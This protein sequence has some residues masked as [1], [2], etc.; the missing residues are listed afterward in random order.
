MTAAV[1]LG[2]TLPREEAARALPDADLL[3]PAR[4][5]DLHRAVASGRYDTVLL[6]DGVFGTVPA[7]WHKEILDALHRGV[8]VVG[9][10]S[11]GAL[12]AVECEPF[13]M[14]G[15]GEV[16]AAYRSGATEDDDDVAV[17]HLGPE[18]AWA[19]LTVPMVTV[20]RALRRATE[21]GTLTPAEAADAESVAKAMFYAT[22]TWDRLTAALEAAGCMADAR[23]FVR[24]AARRENDAKA[25][26]CLAALR[27]VADPAPPAPDRSAGTG[28]TAAEDT[29][30]WSRLRREAAFPEVPGWLDEDADPHPVPAAERLR[31]VQGALLEPPSAPLGRDRRLYVHLVT[32]A[33]AAMGVVATPAEVQRRSEA[34]RRRRGLLDAAAT[35]AW[36]AERGTSVEEWRRALAFDVVAE[37]VAGEF[38]EDLR[39]HVPLLVAADGGW[40]AHAHLAEGTW[41]APPEDEA[42]SEAYD[43]LDLPAAPD[44]PTAAHRLGFSSASEMCGAVLA[45]ASRASTRERP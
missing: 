39:A 33:A 16:V 13:G 22:R 43:L 19:P 6:V 5:G 36:L 17:A 27:V 11:M 20:R 28:A 29:A 37:A 10:S 3:P 34:E 8:R 9:C 23:G 2:P 4:A 25:L 35:R 32:Q 41:D 24:F 38:A 12:R 45:A 44:L 31:V 14:V 18:E 1:F 40:T 21:D 26:D 15:V 30:F 42:V 7:V